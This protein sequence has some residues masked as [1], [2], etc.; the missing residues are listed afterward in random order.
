ML[1][2]VKEEQ[3]QMCQNYVLPNPNLKH[4][5]WNIKILDLKMELNRLLL[6][7]KLTPIKKEKSTVIL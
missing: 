4:L 5:P 2:V 3:E 6:Y 1:N 7:L